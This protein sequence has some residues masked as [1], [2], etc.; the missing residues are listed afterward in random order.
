MT[1]IILWAV[2]AVMAAV[3]LRYCLKGKRR[4]AALFYMAVPGVGGII[5]MNLLSGYTG[6]VIPLN[7]YNLVVSVFLGL[8][9]I[10]GLVVNNFVA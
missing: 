1:G 10:T 7:L 2:L 4:L 6:I 3:I 9:G 8:P 5:A